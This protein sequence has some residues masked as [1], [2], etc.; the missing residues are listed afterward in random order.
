MRR[1]GSKAGA[2][3]VDRVFKAIGDP[4]RIQILQLLKE[5]EMSAGEIL[6]ALD[7]VQSTLSHH[8]KSLVEAE[9]VRAVRRGKWTFYTLD[10][11]QLISAGAFLQELAQGAPA[12]SAEPEAKQTGAKQPAARQTEAK[13]PETKQTEEKRTE[14]KQ[15][16]AP[17][18]KAAAEKKDKK[19]KKGKKGKKNRK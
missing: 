2:A 3:D 8:M 15:A 14:T 19:A 4:H 10:S 12:G 13:Q 18:K 11:A 5:K 9:L 7:I 17:V 1:S 16:D 6:S